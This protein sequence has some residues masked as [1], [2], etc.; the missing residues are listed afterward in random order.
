MPLESASTPQTC[1][2]EATPPESRR[3][4]AIDSLLLELTA[5]KG[6]D[7]HLSAGA[8]PAGRIHGIMQPIAAEAIPA[9]ETAAL[10]REIV[11]PHLEA[12]FLENQEVDFSYSSR[13]GER[14]RVNV[15]LDRAGK[16]AVFRHIP[17]RIPSFDELELPPAIRSF[18]E[19]PKGLV[20]VTG[21]TGSGKSTTLAAIIDEINR[22][23]QA[24]IITI[25]DPIEFVHQNKS[26]LINQREVGTHTSSFSRA[27]RAALREDPDVILV[28]EM[29]DMETTAMALEAAETGHLVFSTLHTSSAATTIDRI[30]DQFPA[31]SQ[32]QIRTMLAA[33]LQGVVAQCL[34]RRQD[35]KGRAAALEILVGTPA[36]SAQIREGKTHQLPSAIQTGGRLG[37]TLLND[38]IL[39]LV[40]RGVVDPQEGY[41]KALDK[42]GLARGYQVAGIAFDYSRS[43]GG[44]APRA[45]DKKA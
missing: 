24:H 10:L 33:S 17:T 6:S 12:A 41:A 40:S 43:K 3:A 28:G 9:G 34:L 44:A 2:A 27:L 21:P 15:F 42:E 30:I 8:P 29:R 19:L 45:G 23:R 20:L 18:S 11:P 5:A 37:M 32:A 35:G 4:A 31:G 38:S 14:F 13:S 22:R 1:I 25:E 26:C 39:R 36:V 7:L 16:G